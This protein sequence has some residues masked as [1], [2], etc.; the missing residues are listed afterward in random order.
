LQGTFIFK[1]IAPR[2][3]DGYFISSLESEMDFTPK[4]IGRD[5]TPTYKCKILHILEEWA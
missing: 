5:L 4:K 3:K 2:K 1:I